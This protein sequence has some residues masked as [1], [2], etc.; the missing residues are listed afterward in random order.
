MR[1]RL[2]PA[3][4]GE[5]GG[6]DRAQPASLEICVRIARLDA[7]DIR[8]G[9]IIRLDELRL[10][11]NGIA[12]SAP[13][14]AVRAASVEGDLVITEADLNRF[15]EGRSEDPLSGLQVA[16]LTGKVR[17]SGRYALFLG[18]SAPFTF[19][20]VPEIEGG[21][22]LRLDPKQMTAVGVPIPGGALQM[23]AEKINAQLAGAVDTTRLPIPVRLTTI[24]IETGRLVISATLSIELSPVKRGR[25]SPPGA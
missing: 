15:L 20:A 25:D 9:E 5:S 7:R 24:R 14:G 22:R 17:L 23:I 19:T 10:T 18:M 3:V 16:M 21:A 12:M 11:G 8:I 13:G 4:A 2:V 6:S 1:K